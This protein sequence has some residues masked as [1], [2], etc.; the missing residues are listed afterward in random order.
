MDIK[1]PLA[2]F[3]KVRL[4]EDKVFIVD[5]DGQKSITN[6]AEAVVSYVN[7]WHPNRR[8]IYQDTMGEWGELKHSKGV[9]AGF[10]PY[11]EETF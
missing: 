6:D 1:V 7:Y 4:T 10:S 3:H 5:C 9:F 8:I 2:S 11:S